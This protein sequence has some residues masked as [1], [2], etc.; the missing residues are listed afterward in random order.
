ML[1]TLESLHPFNDAHE[2]LD[3]LDDAASPCGGDLRQFDHLQ[4]RGLAAAQWLDAH[5][6]QA[7]EARADRAMRSILYRR[8][9]AHGKRRVEYLRMAAEAADDLQHQLLR[10]A[11]IAEAGR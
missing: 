8:Q 1:Q 10:L 11:K 6:L 2:A 4:Q 3:A 5:P 7:A 9:L